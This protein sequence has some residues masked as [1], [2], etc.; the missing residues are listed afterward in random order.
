MATKIKRLFYYEWASKSAT[1]YIWGLAKIGHKIC[2][3]SHIDN[4]TKDRF[5]N[6]REY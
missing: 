5:K 3:G 4:L 2:Y 6:D 1:R